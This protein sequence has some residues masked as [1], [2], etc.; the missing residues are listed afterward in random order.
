MSFATE[1]EDEGSSS[2]ENVRRARAPLPERVDVAI[3]GSGLGGL[4]A[5]AYLARSGLRVAVLEAH[6]VA[7]GCATVFTRKTDLGRYHFDVGLHYI[8]DCEENGAIPSILRDVGTRVE[9]SRLDP[10]GF[11]TLVFPDLEFRIPVDLDLY[12]ERLVGLFPSE[13]RGIDR[14]L[15]LLRAVQ[16]AGEKMD[17]GKVRLG[18]AASLAFDLYGL[19]RNQSRTIGEFLDDCTKEPRLR[20][21]LLGQSGDYGL[22]P[23]KVSAFLHLGLSAH[24]FKGAY[25]TKG[26]GQVIADRLVEVIEANGGSVHLRSP[27]ERILIENGRAVG[28]RVAGRRAFPARELRADLVLSNADLKR[29]L[30]E[31]VGPEHLPSGWVEKT[32]GFEM[33]AAIFLTFLGVK[34]DLRQRGMRASNYWQ[35]DSYDM[36]GFYADPKPG[37][38][39]VPHGCYITSASLKDPEN[40]AHHAPP[41]VQSLEVMTVVPSG[42]GHWGVSESDAERWKYKHD[43]RY[44][45]V[46]QRLEDDMIARLDRLF[47][48]TAADIVFRES[49]TPASHTRYTRATAGTGYGI[50]AT[51]EQF[52][53]NRPGYRG[54]IPGLYLSGASTRAG[55]GIVGAMMSGREAAKRIAKDLG[56]TL[57]K[58]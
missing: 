9:F 51:P 16:K 8:G 13:K 36:E 37:Q 57:P 18:D 41:G 44:H 14:Y 7:G 48:G 6:Y 15:K 54:P 5:A 19:A 28:V 50:A 12:R 39:I 47:P 27:V 56:K 32:K 29:T 42:V 4:V 45:Q 24:Y 33:A 49:S 23:S 35:F 31:L 38:P 46:K 53:R 2:S 30:L 58:G 10:E 26:G 43:E 55:H 22:P 34:G 21:I 52:L 17:G 40:A 25:Y 20:A 3:V 1:D 11:D